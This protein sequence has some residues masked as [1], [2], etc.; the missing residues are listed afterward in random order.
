MLLEVLFRS[1]H[2]KTGM[3]CLSIMVLF[4]HK[5]TLKRSVALKTLSS[6]TFNLCSY[7]KRACHHI[8][9]HFNL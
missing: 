4:V 7:L 2:P 3:R 5:V 6:K 9:L 1:L 8:G